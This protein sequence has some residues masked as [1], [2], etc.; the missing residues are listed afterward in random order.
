[1]KFEY[2]VLDNSI[3]ITKKQIEDFDIISIGS[4]G[5]VHKIAELKKAITLSR[6]LEIAGKEFSFITPKVPQ[7]YMQ[8]LLTYISKLIN[9]NENISIVFNDL[10]LLEGCKHNKVLPNKAII[11]RGISRTFEECLWYEHILR[12][13]TDINKRT[14]I[15]NN[16]Y[17]TNKSEFFSC[18]NVKGIE[19]NMLKNQEESHRN[20]S[21]MGYELNLHY[22]Y[23]TTAFSRACQTARYFKS[24]VPNCTDKCRKGIELNMKNVWTRDITLSTEEI[25]MDM[26]LKKLNPRFILMGNVLMRKT[27]I[28]FEQINYN[29]IHSIILD[30]RLV[31]SDEMYT[32]RE[33]IRNG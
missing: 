32:F 8:P 5:C 6:E 29:N 12:D 33:G 18:Y 10:G 4:E 20:L 15:Q 1:M 28:A 17:D 7:K 19:C 30:A 21:K 22:R 2:R 24:S 25:D 11:G 31:S 27:D 26:E 13:E 16:M 14:I 3:D 23:I 9:E